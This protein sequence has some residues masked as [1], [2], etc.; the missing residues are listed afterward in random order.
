M[1]LCAALDICVG[2]CSVV[3]VAVSPIA[4]NFSSDVLYNV[5]PWSFCGGHGLIW[6]WDSVRCHSYIC[7]VWSDQQFADL[8]I[9]AF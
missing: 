5:R 2:L 4:A 1:V 9:T 8:V 6:G 7:A 3:G